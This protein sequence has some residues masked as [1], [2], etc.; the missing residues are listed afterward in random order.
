MP[1]VRQADQAPKGA[2]SVPPRPPEQPGTEAGLSP[3][4][5]ASTWRRAIYRFANADHRDIACHP[6]RARWTKIA[7]ALALFFAYASFGAYTFLKGV[8]AIHTAGCALG[9]VLVAGGIVSFDRGLLGTTAA[10]IDALGLSDGDGSNPALTLMR[11]HANPVRPISKSLIAGRV[12]LALLMA[13]VVTEQVNT[14]IFHK[15]IAHQLEQRHEREKK[16]LRSSA[17]GPIAQGQLEIEREWKSLD[18]R[19]KRVR[20]LTRQIHEKE[21]KALASSN[22]YDVTHERG[23]K[24]LCEGFLKEAR[25]L[26]VTLGH[27]EAKLKEEG[28]HAS[29]KVTQIRSRANGE[30]SRAE[31]L[32]DLDRGGIGDTIALWA[33]LA[34]NPE[35]LLL[36]V[37]I[38]L[39]LLALDLAALLYK[40]AGKDSLYERRQALRARLLWQADVASTTFVNHQTVT[41]VQTSSDAFTVAA[42]ALRKQIDK[43]QKDPD[44]KQRLKDLSR[45]ML[46]EQLDRRRRKEPVPPHAERR[47]KPDGEPPSG[48]TPEPLRRFPRRAPEGGAYELIDLVSGAIVTGRRS[49]ELLRELPEDRRGGHSVVFE[50]REV[51][52]SE[53]VVIKFMYVPRAHATDVNEAIRERALRELRN[54]AVLPWS[55]FIVEIVDN[56]IDVSQGALWLATPLAE[57]G[58]L[59]IFYRDRRTRSLREAVFV[60]GQVAAG[61]NHVYSATKL[62]HRDIKPGN[63]LVFSVEQREGV[64]PSLLV[65]RVKLTDW[66][67][68]RIASLMESALDVVRGGTL[69]FAPPQAHLAMDADARDDLFGMGCLL[70]WLITGEPPLRG[71]FGE[72]VDIEEVNERVRQRQE[73]PRPWDDLRFWQPDVPPQMAQLVSQ[74]MAYDRDRRFTPAD[75]SPLSERDNPFAWLETT[76]KSMLDALDRQAVAKGSEILVGPDHERP[77]VRDEVFVED[78]RAE[79]LA[80]GGG[81]EEER[82][83]IDGAGDEPT[84]DDEQ[85]DAV[86]REP[87]QDTLD[88]YASEDE[89]EPPVPTPAG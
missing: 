72:D 61:L 39:L 75:D 81:P 3:A 65:P 26:Q 70:W 63:V 74:L 10:N 54:V 24:V 40:L 4:L 28:E 56:V 64:G 66:G 85:L 23:C 76:L 84:L 44:V 45:S 57:A 82:R 55:H 14:A 13:L 87:S 67:L 80:Y 36:M 34:A 7:S 71:E 31:R 11:G 68:S 58:S 21:G 88:D 78:Y 46:L 19:R 30:E 77:G 8:L 79:E 47:G 27:V 50:A 48:K 12:V 49:W 38:T 89:D 69:W 25:K 73:A 42:D 43:A 86:P 60:A 37:P 16:E 29:S 35:G 83:W 52:N 20:E 6:D 51:G 59:S 22:G 41:A 33:Y 17:D 5:P 53:R 2:A 62:V 9:A 32:I 1:R 18:P 15:Q